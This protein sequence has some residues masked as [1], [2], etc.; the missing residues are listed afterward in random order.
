M[1]LVIKLF[2]LFHGDEINI[3]MLKHDLKYEN[4][5]SQT[6]KYAK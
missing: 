6:F 5:S 1:I 3:L 2:G 4:L